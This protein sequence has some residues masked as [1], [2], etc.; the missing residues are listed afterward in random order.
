MQCNGN[1]ALI[2]I[3]TDGGQQKSCIFFCQQIPIHI[4]NCWNTCVVLL[5]KSRM[6]IPA[7]LNVQRASVTVAKANDRP[8]LWAHHQQL[9]AYHLH[10]CIIIMV[11][12]K[13]TM[14][15]EITK[16][17]PNN[18]PFIWRFPFPFLILKIKIKIYKCKFFLLLMIEIGANKV[19]RFAPIALESWSRN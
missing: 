6:T 15:K 12:C 9:W 8:E 4:L 3:G 5:Q 2:W 13:C 7:I 16:P 18:F 1:E 11:H 14:L 10:L 19:T 17:F